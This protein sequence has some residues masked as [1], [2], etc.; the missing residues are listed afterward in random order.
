MFTLYILVLFVV[1]INI[2]KRKTKARNSCFPLFSLFTFVHILI[3][4]ISFLMVFVQKRDN[5]EFDLFC[6][7]KL[8][9]A[10]EKSWLLGVVEV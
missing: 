4:T 2:V 8:I 9:E 3:T 6:D 7:F 5:N 1:A 10:R